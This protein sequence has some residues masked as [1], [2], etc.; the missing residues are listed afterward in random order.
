MFVETG[1][2]CLLLTLT[3]VIVN[4]GF[5]CA[6][7]IASF[8]FNSHF[9][10]LRLHH[11]NVQIRIAM[12]LLVASV[13]KHDAVADALPQ[14]GKAREWQNVVQFQLLILERL[15]AVRATTALAFVQ[16]SLVLDNVVLCRALI[17]QVAYW[18]LLHPTIRDVEV[19]S[20]NAQLL[21]PAFA[22]C[23][24]LTAKRRVDD[25]HLPAVLIYELSDHRHR[26]VV[27]RLPASSENLVQVPARPYSDQSS[28]HC[29][30]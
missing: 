16:L 13:A 5:V 10:C 27:R 21:R 2:V 18:S 4:T 23:S 26:C 22:P 28:S 12:H 29:R 17:H 7:L 6:R 3:A 19:Q 14:F 11:L 1:A 20:P 8:Q 24:R 25:C 9:L 30:R 15:S